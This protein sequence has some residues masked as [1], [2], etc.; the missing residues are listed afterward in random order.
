MFCR[1]TGKQFVNQ[2]PFQSS[3][4][5]IKY[6]KYLHEDTTLYFS[7]ATTILSM[8]ACIFRLFYWT[9]VVKMNFDT[10]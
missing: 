7:K 2:Y 6:I 1:K 5:T 10:L 4:V 3:S 8:K 9:K